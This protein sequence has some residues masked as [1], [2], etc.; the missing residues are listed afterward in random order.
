VFGADAPGVGRGAPGSPEGMSDDRLP[1]ALGWASLGLGLPMALAPG[2][3]ARAVGVKPSAEARAWTLAVAA[4]EFAAAGGLLAGGRPAPWLWARVAGDMK[5][6]TLLLRGSTASRERK[7]AAAAGASV[8]GALDL[9]A[10]VRH[11]RGGTT[12]EEHPMEI[13]ATITTIKGRAEAE[14]A[15]ADDEE[16]AAARELGETRVRFAE[17][18]GDRGTEIHVSLVTKVPGGVV[19]QAVKKVTGDDPRQQLHD[20][21]RRFKQRLETGEVARSDGTPIGHSA[22]TQPK[23]R[24]AQPLERASA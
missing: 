19:G 24:P 18:P 12:T 4:R 14:R 3:F 1:K 8:I 7:L 11:G 13:T 20:H 15:W 21:L 17:A 6:M 23:Q 5:D 16:A 22:K 9:Y 2:R 10:A